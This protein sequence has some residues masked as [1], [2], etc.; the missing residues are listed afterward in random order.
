MVKIHIIPVFYSHSHRLN[1]ARTLGVVLLITGESPVPGQNRQCRHWEQV[2]F[3]ESKT[4][5][6]TPKPMPWEMAQSTTAHLVLLG[7]SG[8][9]SSIHMRQLTASSNCSSTGTLDLWPLSI[10][11]R[12]YP[13]SLSTQY[14]FWL[15]INKT[16]LN[17][18]PYNRGEYLRLIPI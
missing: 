10:Y 5:Q 12:V 1:S 2:G 14:R 3:L 9:V 11:T 8:L 7:D 6:Q 15:L 16:C 13:R 18:F 17:S 4:L